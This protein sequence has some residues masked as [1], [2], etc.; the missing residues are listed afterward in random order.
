MS[1]R[2]LGWY[3]YGVVSEEPQQ[4]L[5][6]VKGVDPEFDVRLIDHRGLRAAVSQ[7]SLEEFGEAALRRNLEDLRWLERTSRGHAAVLDRLMA[8]GSVV[9]VRLCTIFTDESSVRDLLDQEREAFLDVLAHLRGQGEWSTKVLLNPDRDAAAPASRAGGSPGRSYLSQKVQNQ[10]LRA[11]HWAKIESAVG[12]LHTRLDEMATASTLLPAQNR[13]LSGR[14]GD[15]ILNAAYLVDFA[16]ADSFAAA[17]KEFGER[18][19]ELGL[20]VE[21]TGPWPPYNFV[22]PSRAQHEPGPRQ[23]PGSEDER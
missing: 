9:P 1:D 15:M 8:S 16:R 18:H 22:H 5:I 7:V 6:A 20:R 13:Q 21:L 12:Q 14:P 4:P 10:K 19:H 3:L 17:A 23:T 11:D 2:P